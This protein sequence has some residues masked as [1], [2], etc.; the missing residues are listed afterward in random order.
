MSAGEMGA[1]NKSNHWARWHTSPN[2]ST[3]LGHLI[4]LSV[5]CSKPAK[6]HF[7]IGFRQP[8]LQA[9]ARAEMHRHTAPKKELHRSCPRGLC[10]LGDWYGWM[11]P[12]LLATRPGVSAISVLLWASINEH[13]LFR[14]LLS[15]SARTCI[16]D[17]RLRISYHVYI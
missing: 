12:M 10:S 11:E 8:Q 6:L 3:C 9:V 16:M 5:H 13:K 2:P 14:C 7:H 4:L 1:S 17:V 15:F